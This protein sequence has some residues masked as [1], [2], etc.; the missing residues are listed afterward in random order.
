MQPVEESSISDNKKLI[1][2]KTDKLLQI[3]W[4]SVKTYGETEVGKHSAWDLLNEVISSKII[5]VVEV[6]FLNIDRADVGFAG[7]YASF[8]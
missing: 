3:S 6:F 5:T 7:L 2:R 8:F 4:A 1:P